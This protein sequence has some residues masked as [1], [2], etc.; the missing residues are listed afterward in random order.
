LIQGPV[1]TPSED[2][3]TAHSS[4]LLS[5]TLLIALLIRAMVVDGYMPGAQGMELCTGEG[6]VMV[7]I[8][9]LTGE[10]VDQHADPSPPCPWDL[11]L[12]GTVMFP[13]VPELAMVP[14]SDPP[15]PW[16]GHV[17]ARLACTGL[18]PTRA[19]PSL[20]S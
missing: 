16:A 5:L 12:T 13:V 8:D 1:E 19:P 20:L 17:H 7:M 15:V 9:P 4:R 6:M 2:M 18:P 11:V 10:I 3:R 14:G